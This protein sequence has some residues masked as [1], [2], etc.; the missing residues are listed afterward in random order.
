MKIESQLTFEQYKKVVSSVTKNRAFPIFLTALAVI[1]G[2]QIYEAITSRHW[3]WN[4]LFPPVLIG[5]LWFFIMSFLMN[6]ALKKNYNSNQ[7][8][9]ENITYEF[10][11]T[12]LTVTGESFR[13][14]TELTKSHK[15]LE[16]EDWFLLY[17][18]NVVANFIPKQVMSSGEVD[19][20][21]SLL[22]GITHV[23]YKT[24]GFKA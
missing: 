14:E 6:S 17:Q 18:N 19:E 20:L 21:R 7:R 8:L 15:F 16:L 22:K 24:K 10:S 13:T 4:F 23:P 12:L 11:G 5:L 3:D 1:V 2:V 9:K